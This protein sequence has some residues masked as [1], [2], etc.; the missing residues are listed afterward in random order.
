MTVTSALVTFVSR[1]ALQV[2]FKSCEHCEHQELSACL[3]LDL[4]LALAHCD[5]S[6]ACGMAVS[7]AAGGWLYRAILDQPL[8][9]KGTCK[10]LGI[11]AG[12]CEHGA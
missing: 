10:L 6:R 4:C 12:G 11:H 7:Y 5:A 1:F 3:P 9:R 8:R 2:S